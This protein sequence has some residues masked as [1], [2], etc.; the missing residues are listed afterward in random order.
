MKILLTILCLAV[1]YGC[2]TPPQQADKT[3]EGTWK[4]RWIQGKEWYPEGGI[5]MTVASESSFGL[6]DGNVK[7]VGL[8][9]DW[10]L[11]GKQIGNKWQG[12][13]WAAPDTNIK[14][15]SDFSKQINITLALSKDYVLNQYGSFTFVLS[16]DGNRYFES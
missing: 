3:F 14:Y 9:P 10:G 16:D 15:D 5:E 1:L 11:Y 13:W 7:S 2:Q 6:L 8:A 12:S 4:V